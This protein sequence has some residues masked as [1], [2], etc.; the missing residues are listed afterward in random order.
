MPSDQRPLIRPSITSGDPEGVHKYLLK[1]SSVP[2]N[3]IDCLN[4]LDALVAQDNLVRAANVVAS[5][6]RQLDPSSPL[7]TQVYNKYL[8][9]LVGTS[10][11]QK[12]G[13]GRAMEWYRE[14]ETN[15]V[16]A[17][18][19]TFA[20]LS[21]GALSLDS[22]TDANRS[23]RK[24]FGIWRNQGG[25]MGDLLCDGMFPAEEVQRSLKVL[26]PYALLSVDSDV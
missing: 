7:S 3:I 6:R 22:M 13:M 11:E 16:K 25:D 14:M 20:L 26:A 10:I 21:K 5:L 23:A 18:R 19:T 12:A 17:D 4:V 24:I 15:G 1:E 9:G 2:Q 8:E